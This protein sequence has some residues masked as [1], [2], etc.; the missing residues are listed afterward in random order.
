[1]EVD[2]NDRKESYIK[3][4]CRNQIKR[5]PVL[6]VPFQMPMSQAAN[7]SHLLGWHPASA[8]CVMQGRKVRGSRLMR[9]W[10]GHKESQSNHPKAHSCLRRLPNNH[11]DGINY[12]ISV[13]FA[14]SLFTLLGID[15]SLGITS[16]QFQPLGHLCQHALS[17]WESSA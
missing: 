3:I 1:M 15:S 8:L 10:A 6:F 9:R 13:I 14:Y 12:M 4:I 17:S 2:A 11:S 16:P 5:V 7:R